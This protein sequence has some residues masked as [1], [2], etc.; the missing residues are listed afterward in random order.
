MLHQ[1]HHRAEMLVL[2][3]QAGLP[4]LWVYGPTREQWSEFGM[5]ASIV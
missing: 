3:R 1:A 5:S 4:I 2:M